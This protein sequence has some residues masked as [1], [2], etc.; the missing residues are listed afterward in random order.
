V[1]PRLATLGHQPFTEVTKPFERE[2]ST[3]GI[4]DNLATADAFALHHRRK[5]SVQI[6][7]QTNRQG[8]SHVLE[9][10]TATSDDTA[11]AGEDYVTTS[12]TITFAAGETD[13]IIWVPIL[14][15]GLVQGTRQCRI[16]LSNPGAGA[17][18]G[19]RII[20]RIL[21]SDNDTGPYFD[22]AFHYTVE[23]VGSVRLGVHRGD[24]GDQPV[25]VDY[26]TVDG[27]ALA[28]TDYEATQ[29][30][31]SFLGNEPFKEM[32]V[33]ILNDGVNDADKRFSSAV[34]QCL[35]RR[36]GQSRPGHRDHSGF[37]SGDFQATDADQPI[38]E[39]RGRGQDS[40]VG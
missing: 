23:D 13:Q 25:T 20:S 15:D 10:D 9:T 6:L 22:F 1:K 5:G 35:E 37:N 8:R 16:T 29:G 28:G 38:S 12:G 40:G 17:V 30:T 11:I 32:A 27:T 21:I 33:V 36:R 39:S 4:L 34:E 2:L 18:L 3:Q 14:N 7:R 31:L 19:A 26:V 24:D